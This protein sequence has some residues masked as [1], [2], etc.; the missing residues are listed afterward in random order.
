MKNNRI[1]LVL[2]ILLSAVLG[3]SFANAQ[4]DSLRHYL[5]VAAKNNPGVKAEYN[6]YQ[7]S[8]QKIPQVGAIPDMQLDMGFYS[9]S[10]DIIDGRQ[11]ADFTLMQMFPWFGTRKAA[12]N[13]AEHLSNVAFER[14][15]ESLDNLYLDV[16]TSWFLM[17]S[18]QL[19][20]KNIDEHHQFLEQLK[21]L[22]IRKYSTSGSFSSSGNDMSSAL[23][24][25]LEMLE[26]E[27][28]AERTQS[29]LEAE[30]AKFNALLNR[31]PDSKIQLPDS[32]EEIP[33]VLNIASAMEKITAQNP[34]LM[35]ID[36]ENR[37]YRAKAEADKKASMPMIGVGLQYSLIGKRTADVLPITPMNGMDML[38]PMVSVSLPIYRNK[39]KAQQQ[40]SRFLQQSATDRYRAT[41]NAI[42]ADLIQI[43][44]QLD[45]AQRTLNLLEKQ[46]ELAQSTYNLVVREFATGKSELNDVI[47][48]Q[49]QLLDY[50][51]RKSDA[52]VEYNSKVASA[53]KLI[54]FNENNIQQR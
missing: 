5:E 1:F 23:R 9:P 36:Q 11:L 10:M 48:V 38:M 46:T 27:N 13:E 51:L 2:V 26:L 45:D 17:G 8:L 32:I 3:N 47:Q 31:R 16:Y 7:A 14:F 52:L 42:E 37:A 12:Q 41:Y 44:H 30:K 33:F 28:E 53:Q 49:R 43:R 6:A 25:Q 35:M 22:A 24:V 21:E 50:K 34:A 40:E 54:S 20:L 15:R 19:K 4:N 39:Y 18:L 29:E